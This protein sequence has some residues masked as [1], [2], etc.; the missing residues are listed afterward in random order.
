MKV[1]LTE[2][3]EKVG[4][5][6]DVI[7]VKRGYARNYLVPRNFAIYATPQ[8]MKRL[9]GMKKQFADEESKRFEQLKQLGAKISELKLAFVRK[10]D[11]HDSMYGSVSEMDIVHELGE[12][13]IEIPKTAVIMEKHIKQ[14]GDFDVPLRL[15]KDINITVHVVVVKEGAEKDLPEKEPVKKEKAKAKAAKEPVLEETKEAE[16][17]KEPV[18]EAKVEEPVESVVPEAEPKQEDI[19]QEDSVEETEE[20]ATE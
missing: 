12:K 13:G 18:V 19:V 2:N 1:I 5:K 16:V 6:G 14:L 8:N 10:V 15:H 3:I 11:E 17:E 20:K 4:S 9:D 7:N